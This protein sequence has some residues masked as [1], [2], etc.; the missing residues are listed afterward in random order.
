MN[1]D[2]QS[3][4]DNYY[5]L[6]N[7]LA[8]LSNDKLKSLLNSLKKSNGWGKNHIIRL[9]NSKVFIKRIP[10]TT[11]EY[12]N[13]FSTKNI[14]R[15]PSY[16]NYGVGSAGF[17][18]FRELLTHIKTSNWVLSGESDC[19]PL[20][21]HYRIQPFTDSKSD[22]DP[23]KHKKYLKY[24]NKNK[25]IDEYI[26]ERKKADFEIII[27]LEYIP[28]HLYKWLRK[29]P[30]KS[31]NLIQQGLKAIDFLRHKGII[32]FD[33]HMLNVLTDGKKLFISD[34][35]LVLDR[36]FDLGKKEYEFFDNHSHYDYAEFIF[37]SL[38]E[39]FEKYNTKSLLKKSEIQGLKDD[40][41]SFEKFRIFL[42]QLDTAKSNISIDS[43]FLQCIDE[44][45]EIILL[46][47]DFIY[48]LKCNNKKN[49]KFNNDALIKL[50]N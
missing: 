11:V 15:L 26:I 4:I 18:A 13:L 44:Y 35:G 20:M 23:E 28:H 42:E 49:N 6:S 32:H 48:N 24:W 30:D 19:F 38:M 36:E 37:S 47:G 29:N 17:G 43:E 5:T 10:L 46:F 16:Y 50:L 40:M 41:S 39:L 1:T 34:F 33:I 27:F 21:Y 3:R 2:Y 22:I 31:V 12:N 45:R 7:Q 9:N 25:N 8:F 14:Y